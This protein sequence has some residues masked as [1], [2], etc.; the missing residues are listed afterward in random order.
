M[1]NRTNTRPTRL[2]RSRDERVIAGV[3]GGLGRYL[4]IDPVVVRIAIVVLALVGGGGV[5]A[6]LIAW[7]VIP[8]EPADEEWQAPGDSG[9][10]TALPAARARI[11][12][13][14]LLVA[15]G[16]GMLLDLAIPHFN[17]VFVPLLVVAGGIGLVY[18]GMNR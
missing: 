3:G 17:H 13:G 4:G 16:L 15:V 1:D 10:S 8:E 7:L 6:Y 18:Y 12:A 11:V 2:Y 5:L 14:V 9:A